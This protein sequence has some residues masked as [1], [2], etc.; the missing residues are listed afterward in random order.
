[1]QIK[2]FKTKKHFRKKRSEP[3]PNFFWKLIVL[4]VCV[5]IICSFAFGYYLFVQ[6]KD[7]AT[8]S[9]LDSNRKQPIEK[10]RMDKILENFSIREN[11]SKEII[12]SP[13]LIVDPSL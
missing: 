5:I 3:D 1:M 6:V 4:L 8:S 10:E 9:T 11:K 13:T 2:F 7:E 12:N